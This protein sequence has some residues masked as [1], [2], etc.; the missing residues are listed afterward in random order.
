MII[1]SQ[2]RPRLRQLDSV[3]QLPLHQ[4]G[5]EQAGNFD[6]VIA[7]ARDVSF[8]HISYAVSVQVRAR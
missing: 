7:A 2:I 6:G 1:I 5:A 3:D 4:F 8:H